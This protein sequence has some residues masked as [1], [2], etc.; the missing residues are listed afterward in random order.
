MNTENILRQLG[1]EPRIYSVTQLHSAED[2]SPYTVWQIDSPGGSFVLKKAKGQE[3]S[4]Y[5]SFLSGDV[6]YAPRLC[7]TVE[8]GGEKYLLMEYIQGT[9]LTRCNRKG[10]TA[11]LDSLVAMQSQF[12]G[13]EMSADALDGRHNRREH[14]GNHRL[15]RAYDAFLVDCKQIPSTLCHDDL[16]PF[17]VIISDNRGV[18]IDWE[19]GGILPYPASLARL[20]AH[21]EEKEDTFFFMTEADKAFAIDYYFEKLVKDRGVPYDT[22]RKSLELS[23]FYEYCEWVYVGNKYQQTD[24]QRYHKYLDLA[25]KQAEKMGY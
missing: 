22:Y 17:N 6:R 8:S 15:E 21:T 18:F 19:V 1:F 23:L 25:I 12:W 11:A 7:G 4:N 10:I 3:I 2:G 20:I 24:T 16:L 14:L 5:R 9:D 13:R